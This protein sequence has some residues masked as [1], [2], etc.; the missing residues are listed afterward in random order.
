MK[1]F[2]ISGTD[3]DCGK[4]YSACQVLHALQLQGFSAEALKPLA[5]GC[6]EKGGDLISED[7]LNLKAYSKLELDQINP[8]RF[9][10]PV[11][12]HIAA[13]QQGQTL[14]AKAIADYCLDE[15]FSI[16]D[17]L[18]IEGAGGL[19]V[20]LNEKETWIDVLTLSKIP[21]IL[22]VGIKLG[23]INHALL[24][25]EVLKRF[26]LTCCGWIANQIEAQTLAADEIIKTLERRID[27]P[28]LAEIP[29][30]GTLIDFNMNSLIR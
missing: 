11:S 24:S 10:A 1:R 17:Y 12:P 4:T 14:S 9:K 25:M 29:Y 20:P 7:A 30:G 28:K 22:V 18:I 19:M 27:S 3:T 15:R 2:F 5:S 13:A 26:K 16:F 6:L 8:W 23:C 21:V